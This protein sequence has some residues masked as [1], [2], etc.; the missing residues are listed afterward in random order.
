[1][2]RKANCGQS[3]AEIILLGLPNI[4]KAAS[5]TWSDPRVSSYLL[6]DRRHAKHD[7]RAVQ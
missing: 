6:R 7:F 5:E 3:F 2:K 1:M 4:V